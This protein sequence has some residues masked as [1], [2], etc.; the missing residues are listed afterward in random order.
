M[1][2]SSPAQKEEHEVIAHVAAQQDAHIERASGRFA[3]TTKSLGTQVTIDVY[4]KC[5]LG[6]PEHVETTLARCVEVAGATLQ[7]LHQHRVPATGGISGLAV[8]NDGHIS[9]HSRPAAG[10][11]VLDIT[12]FQSCDAECWIA[13]ANEIFP[14]N[15][16]EAR[17]YQ[18]GGVEP[19]P[20]ILAAILPQP[21]RRGSVRAMR[22]RAA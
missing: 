22:A 14:G 3:G 4:G 7:H 15:I 13:A 19:A 20:A 12:T 8:L 5:S 18:K 11:A 10:Y 2:R 9:F 21:R 17:V 1:T 16:V 6:N